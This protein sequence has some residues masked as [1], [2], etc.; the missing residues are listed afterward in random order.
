MIYC[1]SDIHG[2]LDC[3]IDVLNQAGFNEDKDQLYI[4]GDI[5]DRGC[6]I[7]ETYEWV[8]KRIGKSVF[9]TL[10]NH[11]DGIINDVF[12]MK[13]SRDTDDGI[14]SKYADYYKTHLF[15]NDIYGTILS[16]MKQGHSLDE[17]VHMCD[18]FDSLPLYYEVDAGGKKYTLVHA[19][20]EDDVSRTNRTDAIWRRD[21]AETTYLLRK[22]K[23]IIYGHTP[24]PAYTGCDEVE[25]VMTRDGLSKK[26]NIDCGCVYGGK[27]ALIRLD[28]EEV[29]YAKLADAGSKWERGKKDD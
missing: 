17:L 26:I 16:L 15:N 9:M 10:G 8:K 22:G 11:E 14:D 3:L 28:D 1:V 19:F 4:L 20:C 18:F 24:T 12:V 21:F 6:Q 5:V 2:C 25:C 27:L 7:W 13:G 29:W 23:N